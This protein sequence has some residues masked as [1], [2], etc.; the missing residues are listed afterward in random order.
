MQAAIT[1]LENRVNGTGNSG[2]QVAAAG[3]QPAHRDA[4]PARP[5]TSVIDLIS[6]TAYLTFRPVLLEE[7]YTGTTTTTPSTKATRHPVGNAKRDGKHRRDANPVRQRLSQRDRKRQHEGLDL[8]RL[9]RARQP[10][11]HRHGHGHVVRHGDGDRHA[12]A[13]TT[14]TRHGDAPAPS[15]SSTAAATTTYGDPSAVNA[16]TMKLF[17]KL[18]CTPGPN[19]VH[20][21]RQL[22]EAPSPGTAKTLPRG[23]HRGS[24]PS[25]ATRT[26]RSTCSARPRSPAPRSPRSSPVLDTS[27]DQ[28]IVNITLN[29]AGTS[30]FGTLTTNQYKNYYPRGRRSRRH[31][32]ERRRARPDRDRA[33]RRRA[34]GAGDQRGAHLRLVRDHRPAAER[35]HRGPGEPARGTSSST[36]RCR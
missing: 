10:E 12:S 14:A 23:T 31:P 2:A 13:T 22:E 24:R 4:C 30:A 26:A 34:V 36:V 5:P 19:D 29:S 28:W 15:P 1:V 20:R 17:D 9:R 16:A 21:E 33:R 7:P 25:P 11:R 8:R 3:R 27:T 6:T 35:L 32:L 18:V